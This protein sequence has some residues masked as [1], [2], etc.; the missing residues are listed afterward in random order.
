MNKVVLVLFGTL[1]IFGALLIAGYHFFG[2]PGA[3]GGF[4][5]FALALKAIGKAIKNKFLK[6]GESLFEAKSVVL[7]DASVTV[8]S[9]QVAPKPEPTEEQNEISTADNAAT[10]P[11][12][13]YFVDVTIVP[14]P[15]DGATPFQ[16]WDCTELELVS[17]SAPERSVETYSSEAGSEHQCAIHSVVPVDE[18][19]AQ[20]SED[21]AGK[22]DGAQRLRLHVEVP[23]AWEHLK[24]QYYFESFGEVRVPQPEA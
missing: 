13:F 1:A 22:S 12:Q 5:V 21:E 19:G 23:Q 9:V 16:C 2:I 4:A 3:I 15:V 17:F 8:H 11:T 18:A 10:A 24:F 14:K 7:R 6:L 20:G